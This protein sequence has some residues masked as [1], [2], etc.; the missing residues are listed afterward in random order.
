ME[1]LVQQSALE[2]HRVNS[3]WESCVS[4]LNERPYSLPAMPK[5]S[6]II[7]INAA[8]LVAIL[9]VV[10]T[11][12]NHHKL[13][14]TII[15]FSNLM[16]CFTFGAIVSILSCLFDYKARA[17]Y[18]SGA[19]KKLLLVDVAEIY[20]VCAFIIFAASLMIFV[21]GSYLTFYL[22]RGAFF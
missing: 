20:D 21:W 13:I 16:L 8:I 5:L 2:Q 18:S 1:S 7:N 19:S 17:I 9:T 4:A 3:D 14:E 6:I 22:V 10:F 11:V 15:T 12:M